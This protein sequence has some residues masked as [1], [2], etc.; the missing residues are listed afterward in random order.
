MVVKLQI[1]KLKNSVKITGLWSL[2]NKG[3]KE[4][5]IK[6][7]QIDRMRYSFTVNSLCHSKDCANISQCLMA[8][9]EGQHSI[10]GCFL[11]MTETHYVTG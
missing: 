8:T 7:G 10:L 2:K 6:G 4:G 3:Y 1:K 11:R 9:D 5:Y